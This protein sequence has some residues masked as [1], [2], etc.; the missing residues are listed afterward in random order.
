VITM[1]AS[2]Q[3]TD[4]GGLCGTR[5]PRAKT[6]CARGAGHPG[7]CRAPEMMARDWGYNRARRAAGLREPAELR[8]KHSRKSPN[9]RCSRRY[10]LRGTAGPGFRW[11]ALSSWVPDSRP[12]V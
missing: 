3:P 6:G 9:S 1:P 10:C 8:E 5:M 12:A 4:T 11:N 2:D 7:D